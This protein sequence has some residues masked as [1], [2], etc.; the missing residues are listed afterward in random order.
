MACVTGTSFKLL[1]SCYRERGGNLRRGEGASSPFLMRAR[2]RKKK[3]GA[4][5][6]Y[7]E[8]KLKPLAFSRCVSS[9]IFIQYVY[10]RL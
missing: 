3:A 9:R 5:S 6:L 1:V 7:K 8:S 10:Y 4:V 2:P